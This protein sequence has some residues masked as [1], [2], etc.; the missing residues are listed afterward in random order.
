MDPDEHVTLAQ[1]QE[2]AARRYRRLL[3]SRQDLFESLSAI[4]LID[5]SGQK[6]SSHHAHPIELVML[7]TALV[8]TYARPFVDTRG[9]N[10]LAGRVLPGSILRTLTRKQRE[11]HELMIHLRH[12]EIAHSDA[13]VLELS[14]QAYPDGESTI[15]RTARDPL[16]RKELDSLRP[17]IGNIEKEIEHQCET[18]R[19]V[20]PHHTWL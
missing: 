18:L 17:I 11:L 7:T 1:D 12:K 2:L 4:D 8:V 9:S 3:I 14:F 15:S 13:E 6:R 16:Y 20:L 10:H 19:L 5:K